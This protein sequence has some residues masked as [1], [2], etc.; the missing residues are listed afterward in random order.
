MSKILIIDDDAIICQFL[1]SLFR[2]YGYDSEYV[3]NAADAISILEAKHFDVVFCDLFLPD[4]SGKKVLKKIVRRSPD[5][6]VIIISNSNDIKTAVEMVKS[7]AF[8]YITKTFTEDEIFAETKK[9]LRYRK[10]LYKN[11]SHKFENNTNIHIPPLSSSNATHLTETSSKF[12]IGKSGKTAQI[13]DQIRLVA[14]TCYSV[15]I[16]GESGTGK[17]AVALAIHSLSKRKEKPFI[18]VDCGILTH[19][20]A[21]SELFGHEKG[22]FTGAAIQKKGFFEMADGGTI[23]LDEIANLSYEIQAS[24]LR[25]IQ[26]R[27]IRRLGA[28]TEKNI[29]VRI[30]VATN[31][32]LS[33]AVKNKHFREDLYHR[34]NEFSIDLPPL[35]E[36]KEDVMHFANHF[37]NQINEEGDKQIPGFDPNVVE[38]FNYYDWPGNFREL[39][40]AIKRAA[41]FTDNQP[42]SSD[43]L[44]KEILNRYAQLEQRKAQK[45]T[46]GSSENNDLKNIAMEA[47]Q[48][49]IISVMVDVNYNKSQA[50]KILN[51]DRKTLYN[52]MKKYKLYF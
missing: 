32:P 52:K 46:S 36:Q 45:E 17:E 8:T 37:L 21:R 11:H 10:Q 33:D 19:E 39:N 12:V 24:L 42:I 40:N 50:A 5:T 13:L 49:K 15:V 7:G 14:P 18:A 20:L 28:Q 51:I 6:Q 31:I 27:K 1:T 34:I 16:Y 23:F 38:I 26:E 35:R 30:I 4:Q 47:E 25:A 2:K 9:A 41:I 22:A 43:R 3:M 44:P 29:D 48:N